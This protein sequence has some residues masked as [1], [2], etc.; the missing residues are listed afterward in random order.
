MVALKGLAAPEA[1][2]D[3]TA[4]FVVPGASLGRRLLVVSLEGWNSTRASVTA[5]AGDTVAGELTL[6]QLV[7]LAAVEV[8]GVQ[9]LKR[10]VA[11]PR[12]C[13][14]TGRPL[15][16]IDPPDQQSFPSG[17][18][19]AA[20]ALA[21]PVAIAHPLAGLV[22]YSHVALRVHHG[23]NVVA[24]VALGPAGAVAASTLLR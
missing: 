5:A 24:G 21:L 13:D 11:R 1:T 12:R 7:A 2:T 17:H 15:A 3:S 19:T 14:A 9:R 18:A 22:A 16:V 23:G 10:A 4:R 6:R 8:A 20:A